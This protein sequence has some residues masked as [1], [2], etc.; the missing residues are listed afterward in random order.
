VRDRIA[1][2]V[3]AAAAALALVAGVLWLCGYAPGP[4]LAALAAGAVGSPAAL[5]A[6]LLLATPLLLTGLAVALCFRCG[7]WNIGAE[8]QLLVGALAA[9]WV[10]TR[11]LAPA[12]AVLL[13]PAVI[14]AG[15]AAGAGFG[16]IAGLLR[17]GRGVSEVISTLLLNFVAIQ[18]IA[19]AV[20]GPLQEAVGAYPKSD[21]FP[22]AALLPAIGRLH[23]GIPIALLLAAGTAGL[24]LRTAIGFRMRAV[25]LSPRAARFAGISPE[26]ITVFTMAVGGALAGLA[27]AVEVSGVTGQLYEGISPGHGYTAIAVA[28]L[29]RLHPVGVIPAALFFGALEAGAGAMQRSAGVPAV[30]SQIVQGTVILLSVGFAFA[31]ERSSRT[32][33]PTRPSTTTR[34]PTTSTPPRSGGAAVV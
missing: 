8:G 20:H 27:G 19:L 30:V 31:R 5:V 13:L 18:L 34:P 15:A 14:L 16:A 26:R 17:A 1:R 2:P 3:L 9:T 23:L 12:P 7:V 4:A 24:L 6:T 10:A 32:S 21:P 25:G 29:A 22:P 11:G 28:L 33:T